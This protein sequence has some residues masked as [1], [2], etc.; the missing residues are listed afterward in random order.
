MVASSRSHSQAVDGRINDL[1]F[2]SN[3][4]SYVCD[5]GTNSAQEFRSTCDSARPTLLH[6]TLLQE[7]YFCIN[8]IVLSYLKSVVFRS[9]LLGK[10][11]KKV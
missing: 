11:H 9:L 6:N 3:H 10:D 1:I 4:N 2:I 7:C 5:G 8:L